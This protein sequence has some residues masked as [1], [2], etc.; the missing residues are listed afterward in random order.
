M[1]FVCWIIKATDIRSE[2]VIFVLPRQKDLH[3]RA[4]VSRYTYIVC[5]VT[6]KQ[7]T[8]VYCGDTSVA[9]SCQQFRGIYSLS[10]N[11]HL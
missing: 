4:P 1:S 6:Y 7:V 3:E 8:E 11:T 9:Q 10:V 2:Y 5:L